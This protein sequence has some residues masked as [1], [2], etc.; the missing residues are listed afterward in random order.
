LLLGSGDTLYVYDLFGNGKWEEV[1]DLSSENI[2]EINR[3]TVSPDQKKLAI[4]AS[5]KIT[6]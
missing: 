2:S 5:P 4:V 6:Q 3:V 1:A